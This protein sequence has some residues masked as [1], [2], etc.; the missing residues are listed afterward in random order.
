MR[1][2]DDDQ[3]IRYA[4]KLQLDWMVEAYNNEW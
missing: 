1:L 2:R 4:C 3:I